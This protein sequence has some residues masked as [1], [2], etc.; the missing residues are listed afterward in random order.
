M[1]RRVKTKK[2]RK[3]GK[4][5]DTPTAIGAGVDG[6]LHRRGDST[7]DDVEA[8]GGGDNRLEFAAGD[9][10]SEETDFFNTEFHR[11][12]IAFSVL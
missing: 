7:F 11:F 9:Q 5:I 10:E 2:A 4:E 6:C 3:R 1:E 8:E 12:L